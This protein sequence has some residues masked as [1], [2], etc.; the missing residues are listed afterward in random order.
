MKPLSKLLTCTLI[1]ATLIA[2]LTLVE[3]ASAQTFT[4]STPEFTIKYVDK[5][6]HTE[7]VYG[8]DP[9]TG[10]QKIVQYGDTY[11]VKAINITITNQPFTSH[12]SML[13]KQIQL[14]YRVQ[15]KGHFEENWHGHYDYSSSVGLCPQDNGKEY[16]VV[17]IL[18]GD[19]VP[20]GEI[21]FRVQPLV[22]YI[23]VTKSY[24]PDNYHWICDYFGQ[25]NSYSFVGQEYTPS[26]IQ[27]LNTTNG[28]IYSVTNPKP[29]ST[30][31]TSNTPANNS[32]TNDSAY[33]FS[34]GDF[35]VTMG[36][37]AILVIVAAVL[38]SLLT[39]VLTRKNRKQIADGDAK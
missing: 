13:G 27:T 1:L 19:S 16:T 35:K 10:E 37:L 29:T 38:G 21:D 31:Q 24:D 20:K 5:T 11:E 36:T 8:T 22:G 18:A 33:V 17:P 4:P 12:T 2:T 6:Y 7:P 9:Y 15:W 32:L 39:L 34:V 23:N 14:F 26:P 25:Y 28:E 30:P 3:S